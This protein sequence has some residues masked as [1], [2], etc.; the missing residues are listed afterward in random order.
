MVRA[1]VDY[2][3]STHVTLLHC[4]VTCDTQYRAPETLEPLLCLNRIRPI[5]RYIHLYHPVCNQ[6]LIITNEASLANLYLIRVQT[7]H[8]TELRQ[9]RLR[10]IVPVLID[11]Y[12]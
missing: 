1:I 5:E 8:G 9:I 6:K 12:F 4:S 11:G 10:S 2:L 7:R 3:G